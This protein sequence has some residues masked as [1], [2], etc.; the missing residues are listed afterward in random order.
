MDL[1]LY[2]KDVILG[3]TL[4]GGGVFEISNYLERSRDTSAWIKKSD[5]NIEKDSHSKITKMS[6]SDN[7][8]L[9]I[10]RLW[11]SVVHILRNDEW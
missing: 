6:K 7:I 8:F 2:F 5:K 1:G 10:G 11:F 4:G 9:I 3:S